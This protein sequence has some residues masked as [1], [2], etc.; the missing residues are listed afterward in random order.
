MRSGPG[1]EPYH[2]DC[3]PVVDGAVGCVQVTQ[4]DHMAGKHNGGVVEWIFKREAGVL[5]HLLSPRLKSSG[6]LLN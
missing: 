1:R 5:A 4:N 2:V 3:I 6:H